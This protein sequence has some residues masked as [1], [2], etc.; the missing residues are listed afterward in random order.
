MPKIIKIIMIFLLTFTPCMSNIEYTVI[1]GVWNVQVFN[2]S[3]RLFNLKQKRCYLKISPDGK[4]FK[5]SS[6]YPSGY[7]VTGKFLREDEE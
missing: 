4:D 1:K 3:M 5:F 6:S 7:S 2:G